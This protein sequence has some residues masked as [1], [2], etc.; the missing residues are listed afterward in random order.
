MSPARDWILLEALEFIDSAAK[1]AID[2]AATVR[3]E[4]TTLD[5]GQ[6]YTQGDLAL[7]KLSEVPADAVLVENPICQVA[8]GTTKGARH[9]W[10]SLDGVTVYRRPNADAL[11]G[12][13]YVLAQE[14]TLTHPDHGDHVYHAGFIGEAIFQRQMAEELK[15]IV[16]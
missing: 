6:F 4:E 8:E 16:D 2:N 5:V 9:I 14:R 11:T 7:R 15:R 3:I 12:S 1:E 13:I 10:D